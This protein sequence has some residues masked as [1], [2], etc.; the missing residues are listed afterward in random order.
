MGIVYTTTALYLYCYCGQVSTDSYTSIA[1]RLYN[2]EWVSAPIKL[3]RMYVLMI[4]HAQK[5]MYYRGYG[6]VDL[7][8]ETYLR[9]SIF[10]L[11]KMVDKGYGLM[12]QLVKSIVGYV[13]M[14]K[15]FAE[16]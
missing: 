15:R 7:N 3:R 5:R 16:S 8:L 2:S 10:A 9:V 4:A 13:L 14:F 1:D 12:L 11:T 6:V